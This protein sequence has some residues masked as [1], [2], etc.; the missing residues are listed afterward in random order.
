M[1]ELR[2][3]LR[4][5]DRIKWKWLMRRVRGALAVAVASIRSGRF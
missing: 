4:G 1:C 3:D 5:V 2:R